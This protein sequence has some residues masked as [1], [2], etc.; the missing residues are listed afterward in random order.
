[1]EWLNELLFTPSVVQAIVVISM[2]SALG[3]ALGRLTLMGISLGITFVFFVGILAGHLGL[4]IDPT[5]L[6]YAEGFGLVI[7]V[8]ALG[9]QVGP[10]FF[11]SFRRGGFGLNMIALSVV[12]L[13]TGMAVLFHYALDIPLPD[14]VGVLCGAVT[15][16]PALGAAQQTM[17]Q[18]GIY[19]ADPA[20]GCAV[21]YPLGVVGVILAI[22]AMNVVIKHC[23]RKNPEQIPEDSH[24]A[25]VAE[26][27]VTNPG[28]YNRTV[29]EIAKFSPRHFVI[30]RVW[31]SGSVTIPTNDTVI[32]ENDRLLVI[33]EKKD[34]NAVTMVFGEHENVDWNSEN[35][36]WNKLDSQIISHSIM[37]TRQGINGKKLGDLRLR[38]KYGINITRIYRA[39]VQL[40]PT[41][42]LILQLGDRVIVVGESSAIAGVE[43]EL[44]NRLMTLKEPNLVSV[45]IGITLGLALGLVPI[46]FP[47]IDFPVRIGLA[48]GPIIVGLIMGAFGPRLRLVTYTTRSANLML[49]GLGLSIY[50]ACLGLDAG[51]HF[52]ET[53]FRAEGLMWVGLGFL[54]T[55]VPPLLVAFAVLY[56]TSIDRGSIYGMMCGSMSNPMALTYANTLVDGDSPSVAYATVY[57]LTM[58]IRVVIAQLIFILFV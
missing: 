10:A 50:L 25:F 5:M 14:M 16:T 7:F 41:S 6:K 17:Y 26:F 27:Q 18:M 11:G 47:G 56:F 13:G 1:M 45:Y 42:D 4:V 24:Q 40:L 51:A 28:I 31:R 52:F 30:S 33:M 8:Y 53:V 34:V 21:A 43:N 37:V 54:I 39:G 2:I 46:A 20:L 35:I 48:G 3:L 19:A 38:N 22:I 36:D 15:N 55:F 12:L 29:K 9:V 57:P 32:H 23:K 44:G 58:F 49:R